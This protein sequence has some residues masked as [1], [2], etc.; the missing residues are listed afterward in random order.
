MNY[1]ITHKMKLPFGYSI[2]VVNGHRVYLYKGYWILTW[3]DIQYKTF[4]SEPLRFW[5]YMLIQSYNARKRNRE[6]KI[7]PTGYLYA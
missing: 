5:A 7:I 3:V 6:P 1:K 4:E 2:K